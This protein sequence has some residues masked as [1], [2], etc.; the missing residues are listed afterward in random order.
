MVTALSALAI[1]A[2]L[3]GAGAIVV[4]LLGRDD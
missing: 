3:V 1:V 4:F 2:A